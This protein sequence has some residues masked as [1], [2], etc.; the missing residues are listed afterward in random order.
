MVTTIE[1]NTSPGLEGSQDNGGSV[2]KKERYIR[3]IVAV[4]RP[5]YKEEE[6]PKTDYENHWAAQHIRW[7]MEE[8]LIRGYPDGSFRPDKPVTRAELATI[9][10]RYHA[11]EGVK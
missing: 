9:L 10:P 5:D 4:C 3:Q 6:M 11:K 8:G 1:G 2:A 7:A